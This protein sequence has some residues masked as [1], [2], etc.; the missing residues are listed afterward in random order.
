MVTAQR[1]SGACALAYVYK[2]EIPVAIAIDKHFS[3]CQFPNK[4]V[5]TRRETCWKNY[6][7]N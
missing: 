2:G 4:R 7:D 1:D 6:T 3:K 5:N